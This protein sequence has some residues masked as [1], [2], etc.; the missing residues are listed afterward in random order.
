M[1][2][3]DFWSRQDAAARVAATALSPLGWI[4]GAVTDWK[5]THA[6]PF[7]A[8][9]KVVCVGNLTAGGS[10]K[11]PVVSAIARMVQARGLR[12]MVLSRGYGGRTQGPVL[13]NPQT[14]DA[15]DVGDEPLLLA[16]RAPVIVARDRPQGATLADAE[17]AN[18]IVMDDGY[19]NFTLAKDLSLIVVDAEKGFGN[20]RILPAGPLRESIL[21]GLA[22]ADAVVLVGDG[23]PP[24]PGYSGPVMRARLVP[25]AG[26]AL[27]GRKTIAFAGIGRPEKFFATLRSTG[28]DLAGTFAFA[29]HHMFTAGEIARLREEARSKNAMLVTTEKDFV[30]LAP[31]AREGIRAFPVEAVFEE[32]EVL[33]SLLDKLASGA[34][35]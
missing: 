33:Q 5:R 16:A 31:A 17:G 4:Y 9:A 21:G 7:R 13:V 28:A 27:K 26:E 25:Q 19:Q 8:R 34:A 11:T 20:G 15:A 6:Q 1:R 29:D 3:P 2:A 35:R 10:G 14:H 22:R 18:V 23:T 24:L 30:R 12:A 32:P